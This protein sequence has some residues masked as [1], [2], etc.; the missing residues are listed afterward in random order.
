MIDFFTFLYAQ[1]FVHA[2]L[3]WMN[4]ARVLNLYTC[5]IR[6]LRSCLVK[7]SCRS[8]ENCRFLSTLKS[9][10]NFIFSLGD[11]DDN[12]RYYHLSICVLARQSI[13]A[14]STL[15]WL[16]LHGRD[17]SYPSIESVFLWYME[18]HKVELCWIG[19]FD[20]SNQPL[21]FPMQHIG[22]PT[23]NCGECTQ[24]DCWVPDYS[25]YHT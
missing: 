14:L 2:T 19:L 3:V 10:E 25:R 8:V 16:S 22:Y 17:L 21:I 4:R 24:K 11:V 6:G 9:G 13:Y 1:R 18:S 5:I 7:V 15:V 12:I 23:H 20:L